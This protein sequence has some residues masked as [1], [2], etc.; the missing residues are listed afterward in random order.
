[1]F[2]LQHLKL[3]SNTLRRNKRRTFLTMLGIIIG[4]AAVIF[5]NSVGAGAQGLILNQI[6]G[7]G[8]NLIAILPGGS[9]ETGPPASIMGVVITTLTN[10]DAEAIANSIN[11]VESVASYVR[12]NGSITYGSQNIDANFSGVTASYP[13]VE[14]TQIDSGRFFTKD[15]EKDLSRVIVLGSQVKEDLFGDQDPIGKSIRLKKESFRIIGVMKARGS[16]GFQSY[17][18]Q[19]FIPLFTAQKVLL[20]IKHVSFIRVKVDNEKDIDEV[21]VQIKGLLR[22]RHD[23]T[24]PLQDDF[25]VRNQAQALQV[26]VSVTDALRLFMAAIAALGLVVGGIGIMNIMLVAVNERIREI[27]L[28]K[29]VGATAQNI[30]RQFLL[31]TVLISLLAGVIGLILGIIFSFITALVIRSLGYEWDFIVS[32]QSIVLGVGVS[33]LVGLV[34]GIYPARKAASLEPIESLRYE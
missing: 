18:T 16:A 10:D 17:D 9:E 26:L 13:I 3:I 33:F 6:K 20:G 4:V 12:G 5:I 29:A 32:W 31:E 25:S 19:V 2:L 15:E 7:I 30:Q 11:R 8:S 23:I 1:M 28:R 27:G 24:D 34:F 14:E 22:Q 21:V